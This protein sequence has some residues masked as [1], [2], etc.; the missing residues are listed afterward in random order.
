MTFPAEASH[1]MGADFFGK[2]SRGL[3]KPPRYILDRLLQEVRG[4]A[5]RYLSPMRSA[6][7]SADKLARVAGHLNC[8]AWWLAL[9]ARPFVAEAHITRVLLDKLCPGDTQKILAD[10]DRAIAR[11]VDLLGSGP[12]ELGTPIDWH[13]DYK[14]GYR[15]P[16]AYCRDIE[17]SNLGRPS[18]VKFPWEVSRMQ[19]L[20][21]VGQAY[22]LTGDERYALAVREILE[23]WIAD[24]PYASSVNWACTMDVALRLMT[25]TWLF[26]VFNASEA[27]SDSSFQTEFLRALYLHGDFTAR[28]LEASDING[29]HFTADAAGLVFAGLFFGDAPEAGRWSK[30]GWDLLTAEISK[31]VFPDGVDFEGSVAYHRLVQ[32]LFLLPAL[33]RMKFGLDVSAEYRERLI[34]MARFTAAYSRP[35]GTVP[36]WGDADDAR[37]LPFRQLPVNDHRYLIAVAGVGLSEVSLIDAFSGPRSEVLW[38]LGADVAAMLPDRRT[39]DIPQASATFPDGGF[40]ILRNAK[41]HV[42]VDCGPLGQAGRGGHGHNDLLSFEAVLD[43][44]HLVTDCG[45]Y[46]YTASATE[47]N[48]FRSTDYHNTPRIDGEE[49]NRFVRPDYLWSLQDDAEYC[50]EFLKLSA[51]GDELD[52][53]HSGYCRLES[54]VKV[55]RIFQLNHAIHQLIVTDK[56]TGGGDKLVETPLHFAPGVDVELGNGGARLTAG[57][58]RFMLTWSPAGAWKVTKE[59]ARVSPTYGVAMPCQRLVWRRSGSLAPLHVLIQPALGGAAG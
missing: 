3:K 58:R 25:W 11:E 41:D 54:P 21:P 27:W 2:I 5:E 16:P 9:A 18:D 38:L 32:E 46:L 4:Q 15:W 50:V 14:S 51:D 57:E 45:A 56:F 49:I 1:P 29:N 39:P 53:S 37:A 47:R 33:Y 40:Y 30:L 17:Y 23:E 12:V 24:N 55:R 59:R 42:F 52:V 19:W 48:L 36:L 13:K 35:D 22:S 43:G 10:A 26:H 8:R 44:V 6:Q 7:T 20:I 28:N 34:A 31:Q